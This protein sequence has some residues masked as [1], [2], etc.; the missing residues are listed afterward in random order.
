MANY[1]CQ[2]RILY[3]WT[4]NTTLT[5]KSALLKLYDNPSTISNNVYFQR[6]MKAM[7]ST[8][9]FNMECMRIPSSGQALVSCRIYLEYT[10]RIANTPL[11]VGHHKD[12]NHTFNLLM[13]F[14]KDKTNVV[15]V[16][17]ISVYM[18]DIARLI[19]DLPLK[20][21]P[22]KPRAIESTFAAILEVPTQDI[23]DQGKLVVTQSV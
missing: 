13:R 9:V 6:F 4:H 17:T 21:P 2:T 10:S 7:K 3:S 5:E 1:L 12:P 15:R 20:K 14:A 22:P 8:G 11:K 18:A 19:K 23:I 16:G